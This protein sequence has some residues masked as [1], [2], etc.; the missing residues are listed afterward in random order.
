[1]QSSGGIST[2][3]RSV[4]ERVH[5]LILS[6]PAAGVI[7]GAHFAEVRFDNCVTFDLGGTSTDI[8]VVREGTPRTGFQMESCRTACPATS[9]TSRSRRWCRWRQH[10]LGRP[11]R[12]P[13]RR[14]PQRRCR[15]R[16]GLLRA[17]RHR[18]DRHRRAPP[19]R[20]PF[21]RRPDRRPARARRDLA[22]AAL[23]RLGEGLD[24]DV[25]SAALGLLA[26]LEE[27]MVGAIRRAAARHGED[28]REFVIVAGGG[29]GPLH[30]AGAMRSLNMRAAVIP[31]RPGLLSAFG[32]LTANIRHD[33]SVTVLSGRGGVD[34]WYTAP[35]K[36]LR[37]E[38]DENLAADAVDPTGAASSTRSRSAISARTRPCGSRSRRA[39]GST[40]SS[41]A[42]TTS[43]SNLGHSSRDS[44]VE[45]WP[46]VWSAPASARRRRCRPRCRPTRASRSNAGRSSSTPPRAG[47]RPRSTCARRSPSARDRWPGDRRTNGHDHDRPPWNRRPGRPD[48]LDDPD[49]RRRGGGMEQRS[50]HRRGDRKRA[51]RDGLRDVGS[52]PPQR[53]LADH[54]RDARLL[55]RRLHRGRGDGRSGRAD[56]GLP[57]GDVLDDQARDRRGFPLRPQRRR[58]LPRQRSLRGRHPHPRPPGLRAVAR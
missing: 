9:R 58:R 17:W 14:S 38:A 55:L 27:N 50:R 22:A 34:R 13:Q 8:G 37:A 44:D 21:D 16:A 6:G 42:S 25:D 45:S 48:R 56:P 1:M 26:V 52:P 18:A 28:L 35:S 53:P 11:G 49:R 46:R 43:T 57:R 30:A 7:G 33:L 20:P 36:R 15:P 5:Q 39:R 24:L 31:G 2:V 19:A 32:L 47:S 40:S 41:A 3:E 23:E 12:R 29:A 51:A 4:G 54:P 10:R